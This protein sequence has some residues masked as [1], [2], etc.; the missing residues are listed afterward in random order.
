MPWLRA[1]TVAVT[2]GST[3]VT[4]T[5]ADFAANAR[6]GDSFVGPDGLNYEVA[7]VA[8]ATVISILPAY[9]GPT[10]S[11]AAYAIMP[12][13]GYDKMLSDAFNNLNNQFGPKLAALGTT[14]NYDILPVTKGGTGGTTQAAARTGLG[15]GTSSTRD[16]TGTGFARIAI[17]ATT[18]A[19]VPDGT[20]RGLGGSLDLRG[21]FLESGTPAD[22]TGIGFVTGFADRVALGIPTA[23]MPSSAYVQLTV[24]TPFVTPSGNPGQTTL[25]VA[26]AMGIEITQYAVSATT[27]SA[28]SEPNVRGG[29]NSTITSLSG[30]TTA[31]SVA[32]GGTGNNTGTAT[33]LA[34]A[35]IVGTATQAG[36]VPT[37]AII[38]H[39]EL[40]SGNYVRFACGTMWCYRNALESLQ[41]TSVLGSLFVS[42]AASN[43]TFPKAFV[44]TPSVTPIGAAYATSIGWAALDS[45]AT[46]TTTG[47]IKWISPLTGSSGYVGYLAIGRWY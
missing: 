45:Q 40:S 38:E 28:W 41:A 44:G 43:F 3:T 5:N 24:L 31:L 1:G 29:A 35:A 14:G 4:G 12:V 46:N 9:K 19:K 47:S 8:S 18:M 42:A 13:Q 17:D 32:Q 36:G 37:G 16:Y 20:W 11:G 21:T 27:W 15:L 26:R 7:N 23:T 30:L 25:R 10:A 33:K 6:T 34:A 2:N 22:V 39:V